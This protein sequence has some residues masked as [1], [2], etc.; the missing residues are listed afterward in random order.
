MQLAES[1]PF[2]SEDLLDPRHQYTIYTGAVTCAD[3]P[4]TG[5]LETASSV[6][7]RS[8]CG[9]LSQNKVKPSETGE[10]RCHQAQ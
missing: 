10:G 5:E 6:N 1:L 4:E 9:M 7:P 8:Q 3:N 2:K